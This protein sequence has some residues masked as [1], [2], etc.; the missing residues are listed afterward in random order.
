MVID[1]VLPIVAGRLG[2][3]LFMVANALDK[4]LTYSKQLYLCKRHF[5]EEYQKGIFKDF[6]FIDDYEENRNY[7]LSVPSDDKHTLYTGYFQSEKY[8]VNNKDRIIKAFGP[9]DISITNYY[10]KYPFL[11]N[12]LTTAIH[13]RRGDYVHLN[14]IHP[15]LSKEYINHA[16][17]LLESDHYIIFSDDVEWC[18]KSLD[19]PNAIYPDC[20]SYECI[21]LM[22]LCHNFIISNSSFSWWGAYLSKHVDKKVIAPEIWYGPDGPKNWEEIY[23]KDWH[24]LKS[25]YKD[26]YIYPLN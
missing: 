5:P 8:F 1:F 10:L 11:L 9:D 16:V 14:N 4:A 3:N 23:C 25:Y 19:L 26:G 7:N 20:Q 24:I 2:N 18:K 22:S 15:C 12:G 6:T 21:W 17:S 13:V